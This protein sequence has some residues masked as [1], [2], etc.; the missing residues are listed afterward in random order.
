MMATLL[1]GV[2][3]ARYLGPAEYGI[4]GLVMA[5]VA[6][7]T[8]GAQFGLAQFAMREG[9]RSISSNPPATPAAVIR[10]ISAKATAISA[11][12]SALLASFILLASPHWAEGKSELIGYAAA[13]IFLLS[14]FGVGIGLLRGLG[15][16]LLGQT[17]ETLARPLATMVALFLLY[18]MAG[19]LTVE[20][21]LIV[22]A[23]VILAAIVSIGLFLLRRPIPRAIAPGAYQP[24]GWVKTCLSFLSA[25]ALAG[26]NAN[27]PLL[28]AGAFVS[29]HDLGAFR[30]AL[31]S[32]MLVA[33]PSSIANI[34]VGPVVA[35][36]HHD[37]HG[38]EL[39]DTISQTTIACFVTTLLALLLFWVA[40][41]PL[42]SFV[43]GSQYLAA[44]APLLILGIAQ[45][46]VSAFGIVGTFLSLTGSETVVLRAA[47]ISVPLGI[48][49]SIPMTAA[50]GISGAAMGNLAMVAA[51]LA[52][53]MVFHRRDIDAPVSI[54]AAARHHLS[55]HSFGRNG[56]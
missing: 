56:E 13:T 53:V 4:Y 3:L 45:L 2:Q 14:L 1:V 19:T 38:S 16:N 34:A 24:A 40:G 8:V 5:I 42:I 44:Y 49:I 21:A 30:V 28:V 9:A 52:Y 43:F 50:F 25:N 46:L 29:P 54:V 55:N 39:S 7:A 22:Q 48:L 17:I 20:D 27:Y 10:W 18:R 51:W 32:A 31:S 41:R 15:R 37:R 11:V 26:L 36:L 35:R 23:C 6:L 12:S 47:A 33:L